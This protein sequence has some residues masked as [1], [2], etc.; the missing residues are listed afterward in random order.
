MGRLLREQAATISSTTAVSH[1]ARRHADG[2]GP[3]QKRCREALD[4]SY[5]MTIHKI[6]NGDQAHRPAQV[7]HARV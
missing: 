1:T 5:P 7:R 4:Q 2:N 3:R 6:R